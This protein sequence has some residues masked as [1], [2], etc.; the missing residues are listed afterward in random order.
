MY[1]FV[2]HPLYASYILIFIG[3]I[4]GNTSL[5]NGAICA[6]ATGFLFMRM[7]RE[8]R[9]LAED[10]LYRE[11]MGQVRYRIIPLIY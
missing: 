2:R 11:Y 9:H 6:M 4:L 1:R 3:Y 8:E 10:P 7:L 5:F